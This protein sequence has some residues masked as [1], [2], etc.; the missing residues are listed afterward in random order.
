MSDLV[1]EVMENSF[2]EFSQIPA[3]KWLT[4]DMHA[5]IDSACALIERQIRKNKT[6]LGI[7]R[8]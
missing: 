6:R 2:V 7:R 3:V 5:S 4:N 8:I 1:R